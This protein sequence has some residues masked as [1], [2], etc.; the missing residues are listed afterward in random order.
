M[1]YILIGSGQLS[2][3]SN[4]KNFAYGAKVIACDGGIDHC[5]RENVVPDAMVGDFD[6]AKNENYVYFKNMGVKEMKFPTHKDMTDMEIGMDLALNMGAD[7]IYVFGGIGDRLDHTMGNI[8]LLYKP[9]KQ[10]VKAFLMNGKNAV[11]LVDSLVQID[12][13]KG[14]LVSLIPLTTTVKGVTTGNLEYPLEDAT[15]KIGSTLGISNVATEDT[16]FVRVKEGVLIVFLS[17]D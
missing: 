7:E 16:I 6:S 5:R 14:Q 8:H 11:T 2:L 15:M 12:T 10:G 4:F 17:K 1:K 3:M 13:H 9:L